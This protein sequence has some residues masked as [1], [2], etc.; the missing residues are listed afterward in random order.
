VIAYSSVENSGLIVAGYGVALTGVAVHDPRLAAAGL[1]AATLQI[2]AHTAA[3]SLLFT[4]GAVIAPRGSVG[5][6]SP[7]DDDLDTLRGTAR[8]LPWSGTGLAV[9]SLT[10]AGLPLTA[11]FA[12]EWFLL[13]ALMQQFRIPGLGFRLV[14]ALAGAAVALTVGFAGV[15][16][17][18]LTGLVVLG[19]PA[20]AGSG[21]SAGVDRDYGW[22]GRA[23]IVLLSLCCLIPAAVLP[24]VI[25]VIATGLA[26]VVPRMVTSGALKSPWV[27]QPVFGDFSILSPSWLWVVMP[28]L[29]LAVLLFAW[30]ASGMR[31]TRV[32]RVPAWR[33]AT[34]G[35]EGADCYT[36]TGFANPTRRV[37]ATV[38][39]TRSEVRPLGTVAHATA[40]E[41]SAETLERPGPRLGYTS[42]VVEMTEAY[43]Y[44]PVLRPVMAT[45]R[46]AKRLQSGRLDAYLAY[47][48]IALVALLALV[49]ALA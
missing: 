10:L 43:L 27:V 18:R 23:G 3:K 25:R 21:P 39:H 26:P 32:R 28:L 5:V 45:V 35:V 48:L 40:P 16:F 14:L 33:S 36:A 4:A 42:D 13:E 19:P 24:L 41:S 38:L 6:E 44:R 37:L 31:L 1:L 46:A 9:G 30:L 47:M 8:R 49:S 22:L 17:V 11:G 15:T 29:A 12:A 34:A 20:P 2:I 7:G